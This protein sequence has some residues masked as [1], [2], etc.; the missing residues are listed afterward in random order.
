MDQ[1]TKPCKCIQELCEK[2][3]RHKTRPIRYPHKDLDGTV[4]IPFWYGE[5]DK[6]KTILVQAKYCPFCGK[7]LKE[8]TP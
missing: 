8:T 6:P 3:A 2:I 7:P 5:H 1:T 4:Y